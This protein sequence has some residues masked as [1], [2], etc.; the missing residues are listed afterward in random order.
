MPDNVSKLFDE[1]AARYAR[2]ERPDAREYLAQAGDQRAALATMLDRFVTLRPPPDP[3][4]DSVTVM[5]AWLEGQPTLLSLRVSR[6]LTRE[7]VV[8]VLVKTLALKP[9]P[10]RR[11]PA[12]TTGSRTGCSTRSGSTGGC[13]RR[14]PTRFA[15]GSRTSAHGRAGPLRP[16]APTTAGPTCRSPRR[17]TRAARPRVRRTGRARG[18]LGRGRR[19]LPRPPHL[20]PALT[21]ARRAEQ[22]LAMPGRYTDERAGELLA[23]YR[24]AYGGPE[25]PVP[26][27]A[28]AEDLLGLSIGYRPDMACSGMLLPREK[29]IWVNSLSPRELGPR[30]NFTIAHEIGHWICHCL[31][32]ERVEEVYCRAVDLTEDADRDLRARGERVRGGAPHAGGAGAGRVGADAAARRDCVAVRGLGVRNALAALQRRAHHGAACLKWPGSQAQ[33]YRGLRGQP[34]RCLTTDRAHGPSRERS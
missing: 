25:V 16:K 17:P 27:E 13:S 5:G 31:E 34:C 8:D 12:T 18:S 7:A 10:V 23:R 28:I 21:R 20:T 1:F 26:A 29:Q 14:S 11:W 22:S 6:G 24:A 9:R 15:P 30:R 2:G 19:A 3:D 32:G 33:A 4:E